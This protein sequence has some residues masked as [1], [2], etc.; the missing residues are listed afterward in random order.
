MRELRSSLDRAIGVRVSARPVS[1]IRVHGLGGAPPP[2]PPPPGGGPTAPRGET[3]MPVIVVDHTARRS[4]S[5]QTAPPS[6]RGN[7][8]FDRTPP[9]AYIPLEKSSSR[10]GKFSAESPRARGDGSAP[11]ACAASASIEHLSWTK[12]RRDPGFR[13]IGRK[14]QQRSCARC[15]SAPTKRSKAIARALAKSK[16]NSPAAS[17]SLPKNSALRSALRPTPICRARTRSQ[18]SDARSKKPMPS[19]SGLSRNFTPRNI[20][21]TSFNRN[22]VRVASKRLNN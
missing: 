1:G 3:G 13:A 15:A 4:W 22:R 20:S 9:A 2:P 8:R 18:R 5:S 6:R 7:P 19:T 16:R 12:L 10:P 14:R 11:R 21:L 17:G